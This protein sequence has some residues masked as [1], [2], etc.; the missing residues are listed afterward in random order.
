MGDFKIAVAQ[1]ASVR[2]DIGRNAA[3]HEAAMAAAATQGVSLLV[4]PEL[5]LT[6]YELDLASDLAIVPT[7]ERVEPLRALA[8]RHAIDAIVGAP[9][10]DGS[11]KPKLG[12]VVIRSD[13]GTDAYHKMYLGGTEASY[14]MPG[15][16]PLLLTVDDYKVGV[17]VCADSSRT[18]HPEG[19]ARSG[20][21]IYAAGVFLTAEWYQTDVP[22]LAACAENHG[23]L[24]VMANQAASVGS[25]GSVGKSA[26]WT[27]KGSLLVQ[28]AG[29]ESVLLMA[30][31][32][33][34]AWRGQVAAL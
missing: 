27:P 33:N 32:T 31:H 20:A 26:V 5:S 29:T 10:Q 4:F 22:R 19:Y 18:T 16:E 1:V 7:D 8:R 13:G 24:T 9:L 11:G 28:A 2:G 15:A 34:G 23:M 12:A 17:A 3:T 30:T 6:G 21:Q 25:Y 14:F